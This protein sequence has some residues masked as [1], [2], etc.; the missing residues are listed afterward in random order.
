MIF[1]G[2]GWDSVVMYS[3][4]GP[5]TGDHQGLLAAL[6][7][8]VLALPTVGHGLMVH[9]HLTGAYGV[10]FTDED[11]QTVHVRPVPRLLERI[12]A[13]SPEPLTTPRP[14][15]R[16]IAANCRHFTVLMVAALRARGV[17]A[18]ARCGFGGY[19]VPDFFEDHWVCEY[20]TGDRWRLVDGQLD[21]TQ[22]AMFA[23]DFDV[24]DVPR[25]R[26]LVA[27]D[28]W[29]R[30]RAG[31]VPEESFGLS[32][33]KESGAWWIA[34]NLMRDAAAL[35]KVEL[36]PWDE[37][38]A[39]PPENTPVDEDMAELFDRL[40]TA[41]LDPEGTGLRELMSDPRLRV[42]PVVHNAV[43]DRDEPLETA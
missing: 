1:A 38:G 9:E 4:P 43:R 18:R 36:L 16:R 39:M 13:V 2:G 20:W 10:T 3:S 17:P 7:T 23:I 33:T 42:P 30:Y 40:A 19:F 35:T 21:E 12:L 27:G 28:A 8:D 29:T 11:R 15:A 25:D 24:T 32:V 22:K 6:T 41:T 5:M 34:G 14:P 37:W 31:E 26:F